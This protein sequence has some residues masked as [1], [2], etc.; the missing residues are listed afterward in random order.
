MLPPSARSSA[1][2]PASILR[3]ALALLITATGAHAAFTT[4]ET[5]QV[6][7][8]ALSPDGTKLFATNTPDNRL[9]IFSVS[10][11]GLTHTGSVPVGLEPLAVA[12]R[13]N[14]EVWVVNHLSDS[15]SILDVGTSPPRVTRTLLVGD[16][17]R[18]IVFA[19]P[20]G[21]RAFITAAHR[22]Q[23]R[24]GDPQ[25]TT[26]GIG[27]ADV[28]VFDATNLD[29]GNP[30]PTL[31]GVPITVLTL[32]GD[33][34]RALA[35][36]PDGGT[37]YAAV[38]HSGNQT[39]ALSGGIV[40]DGGAAAGP[41][42]VSGASMPGGLPAP[43][44]NVQGTPQP[45]VGL[46]VRFNNVTNHWE[47]ELGRN[48]DGGVRFTLPDLDVFAINANA[49][50]PAQTA[51]FAHVGT[52]LFNMVTNPVSGKVYVSNTEAHNEARFEGPGTL[53]GHSVR[54]H[55]HEARITVLDGTNVLP[56]HL[57]KHLN[58][59]VVPTPASDKAKSFA[60]P[61]AMAVTANGQTLYVAAFGSSQVG[62]FT[63]TQIEADTFVPTASNHIAVSGGGPSGLVLDEAHGRLY[64]FTRFDDSI[65]VINTS[66]AAE[67]A[68]LPVF[69]P[70]PASVKNGRP[71][72]YDAVLTS[73]NGETSCS[74]CHIF[75]D[76]DSLAWD[77]GNPDDV[78][79]NN[80]NPI[81]LSGGDPSFHPLKGPM[82]TQSLRGMANDGPMHWR[83]DRTGGN[84]VGGDPLAEDQAFKKFII[85]FDGLL[86]RGAPISDP[87]MQRF[88][89][90]IL[91]VMYPPNPIRPLDNQLVGAALAGQT[92]FN[93]PVTDTVFDC[94]GCHVLDPANGHFGTDGFT[95]FEA[96]TQMFKIPHLRNLY[97]KVG[98]FGMP[99]VSGMRAGNNGSQG[100]QVR[101]FGFLHDGSVDTTFRFHRA[102]VFSNTVAD[103]QNLEQF[104]LQFDS[105]LAPI[106]GQ[107]VTLTS[108]NSAVAGPRIDLLIARAAANECDVVVKGTISGLQRGAVRL[109]SGQF[110]TDRASE[111]LLSDTQVRALATAG[112]ELTYTCVP[113]GNGTRI[114]VDRDED[115]FLDRTEIDAGSDPADPSSI[116]GGP[117]TTTTTSTTTT[118][119]GSTSTTSTTTP[120]GGL[121]QI[122]TKSLKLKDDLVAK[123]SF[124]FKS[125]NKLDPPAN[126][127]VP[128]LPG[129]L[130]DPTLAGGAVTFYNSA[131]LTL[132]QD[133]YVLAAAGWEPLGSA[134]S[135]K[136]W[137]YNGKLVGDTVV[138][139]VTVKAD[140]ISVK[141][142]GT[143]TLNEPAQGR[144]ATRLTL[145]SAT[146]CADAP[147]KTSGN[148][149]TSGNNDVA[150]K[151]TAQSKTPPPAVCPPTH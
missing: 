24:P 3:A 105:N 53:A 130:G 140:S 125:G 52:V 136:G 93:G 25:L 55:L 67:I 20:G 89:D 121:V 13:S 47:D 46:I 138:K 131:G 97:Q 76:F 92:Q 8:L 73:S 1:A 12:A 9:E 60:T 29:N 54:G 85:A 95:T 123:K 68:H 43:N 33:T 115:G 80:P 112:Q 14:S 137:K 50:T 62:V 7:P 114:G 42:T 21:N 145:G 35:T 39:T 99:A 4:F 44:A 128:P 15:V 82:T 31:G 113:P 135:P 108:T 84:D 17:P 116:P 119:P 127:I 19:G 148:P 63:T 61:T 94:N 111:P 51:S 45:E 66:T 90:F 124:A 146:W 70:E 6:R 150:G 11:A 27:R 133:T 71:V 74:A 102:N 59:N 110:R 75:G 78:V 30:T 2:R 10:G 122:Q 28:W 143:Y 77:L 69:N 5:G 58:Y 120:A 103:A 109:A 141:G 16:E 98:M 147:A 132:D 104:M 91:Q 32:F 151:F 149:P 34:P 26:P 22:G 117:T 38:F 107:Q 36:S 86:G 37:V 81:R 88:T 129:S 139:S 56:R 144:I 23:N 101:G 87:D 65:S 64:V 40:C 57:N 96:E 49:G 134:T 118:G 41:C 18:D 126:R 79:L 106:V 72:L 83:G 142:A 48:W 100:P